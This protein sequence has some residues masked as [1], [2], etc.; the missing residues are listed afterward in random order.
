MKAVKQPEPDRSQEMTAPRP[1]SRRA[2]LGICVLLA[3]A[4][5]AVFGQT[6]RYE[7]VNYD[8]DAY[9]YENPH[10]I[11]GLTP[12]GIVWA[13]THSYSHNW[14]PLTWLSHMLDCQLW[15]LNAGGHH[16]TNVL[17]HAANAVLLFLVLRRM[18]GLRSDKSAGAA[19]TPAGTLWPSAFV[20]AVFAIHP[21]RVESVAWVAE[22]K[23]VLSAFFF[24]LTLL[25]YARY[26]EKSKV[27]SPKSRVF[28][29]LALSFFA[30]GLMSKPMLVTL[31]F[32]LLLL[33]YWPLRRVTRDMWQVTSDKN[34]VSQPLVL[35]SLGEG[36]STLPRLIL[37]KLP[38][39]LLAA[40]SS[41]VTLLVQERTMMSLGHL[42]LATRLLNAVVS[43]GAYVGQMVWPENLAVL[44]PYHPDMPV[45]PVAG[46]GV[47]LL[48]V[49]V[50]AFLAARRFPYLP[51]GW[52]WYLGMS[53]PVIGIV[54]VGFQSHADRYTYLPQ[55]GLYVVVVWAV[56]D[57]T[58]SWRH[59][60]QV[61]GAGALVVIA[62]LMVCA[63]K[64]TSYWR[65]SESLWTHA[66]ACTS[67]NYIAHYNLGDAVTGQGRLAEAIGH[68]QKAIE[69]KPDY[70]AAYYNLGC[71]FDKQG[72][73]DKA[74]A[75]YQKALE[76]HPHYA[77]ADNNLGVVLLEEG[78]LDEAVE[79]CQK[80]LEINPD[81][82]EA[83]Y[84]LGC[85]FDKQDRL[86]EAIGAYQKAIEIKPDYAEAHY[87][88]GCVFDKQGRLD[89]A[90]EQFQ[91][92]IQIKPDYAGAHYNLAGVFG[93]RNQL[94]AAAE[95]YRKAVEIKPDYV[96]AHGNLANVLT[97]QGRL[98]EALKEY[99]RTLELAPHSAQAHY[100]LGLALQTQ[101][102]FAAASAEYQRALELD[103]QHLP[104][105]LNLAWLLATGPEASLR[106]GNRA[107]A[108][109]RQ[110]EQLANQGESPRIFDTLAAAYAEAG[111]FDEAVETAKR[112]LNLPATQNN[113]PLAEAI[114]SRLKLYEAHSPYHEKP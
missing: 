20:A 35:R 58:A 2:V 74:I 84:N 5:F 17:L 98:D 99:Q 90:I 45:W 48:S 89:E 62:A 80:A 105:R 22:R 111:R 65:N 95:Q 29:G 10:V 77:K 47:L 92:A 39:F 71:A 110:A 104:A 36:G 108:L 87:N 96:D 12:A 4:V 30:L 11:R 28:Y 112:A 16:L 88:L 52:L 46:A 19:A 44:Y 8:D 15:G 107:V 94:E 78:R 24:L 83:Y 109:A 91:K 61:L 23:D 103:P 26:V 70:A 32:V 66:L 42:P 73:F 97:A 81:Y 85:A 56:R 63:W 55:I 60:R 1:N 59:R 18:M 31:P 75:H 79:H 33:D 68:F 25:M 102:H 101:H 93:L 67:G 86:A 40:G 53:A 37:E 21:L 100:K 64:Q 14:H 43:C 114:Q 72:R 13:F 3:L 50:V 7:F 6:L 51:V 57:L 49:T 69:I 82:V 113:R 27:R 76:I 34:S 54:Q 41:A 9:V 38:L 106:D